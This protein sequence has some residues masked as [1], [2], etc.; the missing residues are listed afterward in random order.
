MNVPDH[1]SMAGSPFQ[2]RFIIDSVENK[3]TS[4]RNSYAR[5]MGKFRTLWG[6]SRLSEGNSGHKFDTKENYVRLS[7]FLSSFDNQLLNLFF[8]VLYFYIVYEPKHGGQCTS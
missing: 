1:E 8:D 4:Y 2:I 3:V 6:N 5:N 7:F